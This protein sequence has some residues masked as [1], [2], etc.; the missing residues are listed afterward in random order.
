MKPKVLKHIQVCII[1]S[2]DDQWDILLKKFGYY[3]TYLSSSDLSS[4]E[5]FDNNIISVIANNHHGDNSAHSKY[6]SKAG[7]QLTRWNKVY[8]LLAAASPTPLASRGTDQKNN[9]TLY[10]KIANTYSYTITN[11][12]IKWGRLTFSI[13]TFFN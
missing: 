5:A 9:N 1:V 6:V 12:H 11:K 7:I 10:Y 3:N 13:K 8:K 2:K 4:R